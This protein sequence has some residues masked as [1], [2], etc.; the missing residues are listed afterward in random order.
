M[1]KPFFENTTPFA[2]LIMLAFIML[3]S[4]LIISLAGIVFAPVVVGVPINEMMTIINDSDS[5]ANL[6]LMRYLQSLFAIGFFIIPAFFAAWLFSGTAIGYFGLRQSASV[7]WFGATLLFMLTVIPFINL[8]ALLNEMIVLPESL[9]G[10]E[11][12]MK[13]MEES[14]RRSVQLFV[15]VDSVGGMLFNIFMLAILPAVGEELIF[16]G[17]LHKIFLQWTGN[18]YITVILTGFLFSLMHLQFYGF[19]PRWLLGVILGYMLVWSGTIWIPVFAH[20]LQ[21]FIAVFLS[22]LIYKG[23]VP[24]E[25]EVFGSKWA[26]IP[27]TI[28][29]ALICAGLLWTMRQKK[30]LAIRNS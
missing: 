2:Q 22:W 18:I 27:I 20:F 17:L 19:F 15:N 16:R 10:I 13:N 26:E 12:I 7:K 6:N 25:I 30:W 29:T 5:V 28:I 23:T 24:E 14:A 8:L 9:S 4:F 11:Q 21:N 3:A 1:Q